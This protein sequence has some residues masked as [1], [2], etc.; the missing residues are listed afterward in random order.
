M[1]N[2]HLGGYRW[3]LR[4]RAHPSRGPFL[5]GLAGDRRSAQCSLSITKAKVRVQ[6]QT[7]ELFRHVLVFSVSHI[8][9]MVHFPF[10]CSADV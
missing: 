2:E 4:V 5:V 3:F 6:Q 1:D 10:V 8:A 9:I 7:Q